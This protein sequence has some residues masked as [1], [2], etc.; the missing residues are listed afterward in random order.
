MKEII[1]SN[2]VARLG[3]LIIARNISVHINKSPRNKNVHKLGLSS[4]YIFAVA[5]EYMKIDKNI[6]GKNPQCINLLVQY[7]KVTGPFGL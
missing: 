7:V 5:E 6:P 4:Q 2:L 1:Q 3:E